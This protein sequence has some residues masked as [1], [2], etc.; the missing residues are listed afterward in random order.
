MTTIDEDEHDDGSK[1]Y[2][3][4]QGLKLLFLKIFKE[5]ICLMVF[6]KLCKGLFTLKKHNCMQLG[7]K[8][9]TN[10]TDHCSLNSKLLKNIHARND[11][12]PHC[13]VDC[14]HFARETIPKKVTNL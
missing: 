10:G 5:I 4:M 8:Y 11:S 6:F 7:E 2:Y 14:E 13:S 12:L 1:I 3:D 9:I